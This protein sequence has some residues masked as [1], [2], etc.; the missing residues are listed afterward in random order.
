MKVQKLFMA[1]LFDRMLTTETSKYYVD[2][3]TNDGDTKFIKQ[4]FL[5]TNMH[6]LFFVT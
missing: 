3:A 4:K 2:K 1:C 5:S 6:I